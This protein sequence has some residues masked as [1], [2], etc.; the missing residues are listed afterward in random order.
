M[1]EK[2]LE[3]EVK[4]G[5][6]VSI[7]LALI[8]LAI[9]MLGSTENILSGKR[10]YTIH[11]KDVGGLIQGAKVVLDGVSIGTVRDMN[12]DPKTHDIRVDL[13]ISR[14]ASAWIHQDATAEISTQGVLGDK[15]VSISPGSDNLPLLGEKSD[16]PFMPSKDLSQF[17]TKGDQLLIT[18]N[19]LA[20]NLD[21]MV[22]AFNT[23]NRSEIFFQ[24]MATSA[25]NLSQ[26]S[27]KINH[28][29]DN[30][31]LSRVIQNLESITDKINGG[32]GTLGA[33]INDPGLY[34][35][36]K[37]LVGEA[38]RNRIMR[39]L[40]RQT[41]QDSEDNAARSHGQRPAQQ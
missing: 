20:I 5:I 8:M 16:I 35:S 13:S 34:D 4:V 29:L 33:L 32:S 7:G 18:L 40:V 12:F 23:G 2:R 21:Q 22:R 36:A 26:A 30:I 15:Y 41:I 10:G 31:H 39:N 6:F 11:V 1:S 24:G 17:L 3:T 9:L 14:D 19:S 28:Q 25:R 37:L 38:N 27:E